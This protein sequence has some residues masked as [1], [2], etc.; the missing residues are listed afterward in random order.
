M[1][2]KINPSEISNIIQKKI[3][4]F[5]GAQAEAN[6]GE[7]ISTADGIVQIYGLEEAMYGELLDF[8]E[9][10]L[11][12]ALNLETDSVGAVVLGD[13]GHIKE[14]QK[15]KTTGRILEVPVGEG[16]KGRVIDALGRPL[17]GKGEIKS[18]G[19]PQLKLLRPVLLIDSLSISQY[20]QD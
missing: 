7:V 12:M 14:G 19:F 8:G 15:V 16:L 6:V 17:D 5:Q 4:G 3:D 1:S 11:G 2:T 18:D 9:G 10:T 13:A 20:K